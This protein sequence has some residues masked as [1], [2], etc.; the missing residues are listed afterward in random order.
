MIGLVVLA[1]LIQLT[2]ALEFRIISFNIRGNATKEQLYPHEQYWADRKGDQIKALAT[3]TNDLPSVLGLQ[4]VHKNQLDDLVNGLSAET[5]TQWK[6]FGVASYD[7][8]ESGEIDA[9]LFKDSEWELINGTT[10]WLSET[11]DVPSKSWGTLYGRTVSIV[12]LKYRHSDEHINFFTTHFDD[13]S[14][15]ARQHSSELINTWANNMNN[16]YPTF[17]AGDLNSQSSDKGYQTLSQ[18]MYDTRQTAREKISG[19]MTYSGFEPNDVQTVID[20]VW[21]LKTNNVDLKS[22]DIADNWGSQGDRYSDHR[23]VLTKIII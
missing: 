14:E 21:S 11:P 5:K 1:L 13:R 10:K 12:E 22:Y 2:Q 20:F 3:L 23:A 18:S 15:E 7:G 17:V 6:S 4:E 19:L 16:E 8:K 9:V